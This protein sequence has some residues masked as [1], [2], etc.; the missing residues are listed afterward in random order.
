MSPSA[1][2][3]VSLLQAANNKQLTEVQLYSSLNL[4]KAELVTA[5]NEL[6]GLNRLELLQTSSGSLVYKLVSADYAEKFSGL[7][8]EQRLVYQTCEK[9]G[10]KVRKIEN[11]QLV[12][13]LTQKKIFVRN[14][15]L[16]GYLDPGHQESD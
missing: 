13:L 15:I 12:I 1:D 16:L 7:T 10:D 6:L 8:K 14:F 5:I 11:I 2:E 9:A 3:I 4:S